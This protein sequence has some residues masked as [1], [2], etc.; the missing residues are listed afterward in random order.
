MIVTLLRRKTSLALNHGIK[1][2]NSVQQNTH[3]VLFKI[4]YQQLTG[5]IG[6]KTLSGNNRSKQLPAPH[7]IIAASKNHSG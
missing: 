6:L 4:L 2:L 7:K 5:V 3:R 1:T